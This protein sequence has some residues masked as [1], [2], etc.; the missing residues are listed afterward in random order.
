MC[1][2]E[3]SHER[4]TDVCHWP[5]EVIAGRDPQLEKAIEVILEQLEANPPVQYPRPPFPVRVQR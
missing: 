3:E 5:A 4:S 2:Q 1:P